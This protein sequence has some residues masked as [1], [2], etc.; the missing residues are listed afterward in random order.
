[1]PAEL[2]KIGELARL[3]KVLPSTIHYY[4]KEG[5]LKFADETPGG[6]RLYDRIQALGRI[7]AIRLLQLQNRLTISE[8]KKKIKK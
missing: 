2:V 4:T 1:M 8:I 3:A 5:L 7:R 6:Y